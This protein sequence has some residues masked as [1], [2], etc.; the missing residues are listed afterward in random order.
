MESLSLEVIKN[1]VDLALR[2]TVSGHG[3]EGLTV[4]LD[5]LRGLFQRL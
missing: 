3:E 5:V 2:N 1:I 4:G